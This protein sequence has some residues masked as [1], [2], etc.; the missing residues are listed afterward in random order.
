MAI[1]LLAFRVGMFEEHVEEASF[2][3]SQRRRLLQAETSPWRDVAR[4]EHRLEL[5]IDALVVGADLALDVCRR[6]AAEGDAGELYAATSVFCRQRRAMLVSEVL[7]RIDAASPEAIAAV[8]DALKYEL[9]HDWSSFV[10]TALLR[11]DPRLAPIL[12][13]ACGYRRIPCANALTDLLPLRAG[14]SRAVVRAL[15]R[16]RSRAAEPVLRQCLVG[17]DPS[18]RAEALVSLLRIGL[19][20]PLRSHYLV[21]QVESWPRIALGL[22]GDVSALHA[23]MQ[24]LASG[25]MDVNAVHAIGLLGV[26]GSLRYLCELLGEPALAD[27]AAQALNWICGADLYEDV[28]VEET[29]DEDEL[30]PRELKAWRQYREAPRAADGKPFGESRRKLSI[31][32]I[33][34]THWFNDNGAR[35]DLNSRYRS[36][37]PYSPERLMQTLGLAGTDARLRRLSAHELVIRYGCDVPFEIDMPVTHQVAAIARIADWVKERAD[38]FQPGRWY[39]H[40]RVQ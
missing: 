10:E 32:P 4:F 39:L 23:L 38:V 21:S 34:W 28:F 11:Q 33:R 24:P 26:A 8:A 29:V 22:G 27:A 5:H 1:S 6:L 30:F 16:L 20:E 19:D 17:D 14:G 18:I 2:L 31:D 7:G 9:P 40:G 35:F 37:L 36:G 13:T 12:A 3:Y 25:Q 15:G